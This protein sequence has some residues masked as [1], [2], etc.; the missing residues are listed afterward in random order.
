MSLSLPLDVSL[1]GA[2]T[3]LSAHASRDQVGKFVNYGARAV[4]GALADSLA[5]LPKDDKLARAALEERLQWWKRLMTSVGDARRTVRWF[6]SLGIV[7]ALKK[8]AETGACPWTNKLAFAASQLALLWW[9]AGDHW[10]WLVMN[11]LVD[12]DAAFSTRLK[13]V[14]FTGFVVASSI[15]T[16]YFG[17]KLA[18]PTP[19]MLADKE[20]ERETQRNL[21]KA[22]LTL[23]ATLHISEIYQTH[24][25]V[26]GLAGAATSAI[27][28]YETFP[29]VKPQDPAKN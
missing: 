23:V 25:V 12:G 17:H 22:V 7:L 19:A 5:K 26:C 18:D 11:K 13:N 28:I 2:H 6:S 3:F 8:L 15:Q 29:R 24:E 10:R 1:Q 21:A 14:S 16:A 9:H 20:K 4:V 27:V